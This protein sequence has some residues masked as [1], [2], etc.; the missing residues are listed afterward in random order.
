MRLGSA[1]EG[2]HVAARAIDRTERRRRRNK[3]NGAAEAFGFARDAHAN[4]GADLMAGCVVG[5]HRGS[6]KQNHGN[7]LQPRASLHNGAEIFAG[8]F[9]AFGLGQ[10][11]VRRLAVQN[12]ECLSRIGDDYDMIAILFQHFAQRAQR[13]SP[14][15]R[16]ARVPDS[17]RETTASPRDLRRKLP[18]ETAGPARR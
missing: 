9:L 11:D 1:H 18:V 4:D 15:R 3:M 7:V 5:W 10:D 16:K 8:D 14:I 13:Q 6:G 17:G 12:V 2:G